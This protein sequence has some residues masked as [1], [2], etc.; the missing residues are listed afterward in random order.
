MINM[1]LFI[2]KHSNMIASLAMAFS[3]LAANSRCVCIFHQPEMP[4]D[5]RYLHKQ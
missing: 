1:K 3:F 4:D 2:K 5:L